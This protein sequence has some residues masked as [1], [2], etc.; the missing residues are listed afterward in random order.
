MNANYRTLAPLNYDKVEIT[1]PNP[2]HARV[3]IGSDTWVREIPIEE[4]T[5]PIRNINVTMSQGV[6]VRVELFRRESGKD[7]RLATAPILASAM[8]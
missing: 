4:I 6:S 8:L 2:T 7:S 3:V 5:N 1:A